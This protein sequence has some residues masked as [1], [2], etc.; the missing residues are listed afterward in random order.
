MT[1]VTLDA[2]P[3]PTLQGLTGDLL[4]EAP[5]SPEPAAPE[6]TTMLEADLGP[7]TLKE[8]MRRYG[9]APLLTLASINFVDNLDRAAFI[10]LAPEIRSTFGL[11]QAAINGINGISAILVVAGALPFA[12][13]ADRGNRVRLVRWAA[14][15]WASLTLLTAFALNS[16]QLTV[17]RTFSGLGQA[18]I[19][20]VHGSLIADY[21]PLSARGR[22]YGLH[23]AAQPLASIVG[24]LLAGGI[25]A[26]VGGTAGWRWAFVAIAPL[27]LAVALLAR[28]LEEPVRGA[29]DAEVTGTETP[30]Q[31]GPPVA[32]ATGM[33][34]L[35]AI[36]TLRALYLGIGALGFGL[37]SGPVL[38]SQFLETD[39][40][41]GTFGRGAV[42]AVTGIGTLVGL[43]IGGVVGDR[44]FRRN[45][46]W[47][48]YLAGVGLGFYTVVTALA[49][50]L[51]SVIGV[52]LGLTVANAG[53]GLVV[54]PIRQIVAVTSPPALRALSFAMLG[55]F[56]LL[57]GGFLGGVLLGAV[58][59]ATSSRTAMTL[60]VLPGLAAGF[61]VGGG[62]RTVAADIDDAIADLREAELARAR[63]R[64]SSAAMLEIRNLDFAYGS[65][66][67]LFGVDLDVPEGEIVALLGTN[68]A[69]KSTLL[70]AVCGLEHPT[71]GSI[72]FAG[73]DITYTEAEQ[74]LSLGVTQMP[75]GKAV[76]PGLSVEENLLTGA[77]SFRQERERIAADIAQI[78]QWFPILAE[79]RKQAASTLSGGEQQMLALSKAFL[80]RPRLLCIDELS[81]GLAPA[82]VEQLFTIVKEIH[83]RGTTI[84]IVE[85]SLNVAL[86]L[87]TTAVFMEKGQ[88]RYT[89]PSAELLDRPDLLRSVFLDGAAR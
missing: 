20:P 72:R 75:G 37:V 84:V 51:P 83:A 9:S 18:A 40:G 14:T 46:S 49:L 65:T 79:R 19:E 74:V 85:Q 48:L 21:Y 68:G 24:P 58:A 3:P 89:G 22:A 42:F 7:I 82:V 30:E 50:Y 8:V 66:Q 38:I 28:R 70:R 16:I 2:A 64:S 26:I 39:L 41:V 27:G 56:I 78:E 17:I 57:L 63:A 60:L 34:R 81:L 29:V 15:L 31:T 23:Q 71:R 87:A 4:A 73:Q 35:L 44:L 25:A 1:R 47:P 12:I 32:L 43:S 61:L 55:I 76:F 53:I 10:T 86:A 88:V 6:P 54:A 45:P 77:F 11:S 67:V 59:D 69:G 33:R 36:P 5:V 62:T 80:T 13:L 52:T